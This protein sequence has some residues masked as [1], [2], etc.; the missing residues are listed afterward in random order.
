M[1]FTGVVLLFKGDQVDPSDSYLTA[2]NNAGFRTFHIP[3][4]QFTFVNQEPL[5][6]AL[7]SAHKYSGIILT[8]PRCVQAVENVW[9]FKIYEH[10]NERKVFVVGPSTARAVRDTLHLPAEGEETGSAEALSVL[11]A[12]SLADQVN[13][14]PF[15]YPAS[16]KASP[17]NFSGIP[18]ERITAYETEECVDLRSL[19]QVSSGRIVCV[20][21]SPSGVKAVLPELRRRNLSFKSIAIGH[22]TE[23]ALK[24]EQQPVDEVCESPSPEALKK[25]LKR[26]CRGKRRCAIS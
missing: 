2:L 16:S 17:N 9:S 24:R 10:W 20:F 4:L 7:Q 3:V 13:P 25:C 22:T 5:T 8:S 23:E 26:I 1:A 12:R 11:I 18:V 19:E 14:K 21:F 6:K 15:L